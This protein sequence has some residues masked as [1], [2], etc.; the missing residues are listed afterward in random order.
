MRYAVC[1]TTKGN[2]HVLREC[3]QSVRDTMPH[4]ALIHI[5]S[6][7]KPQGEAADILR[8]V[9]KDPGF[10]PPVFV[11]GCSRGEGRRLAFEEAKKRAPDFVVQS[12][13]TD[14]VYF[15][16]TRQLFAYHREM[17]GREDVFLSASGVSICPPALM[18]ALGGWKEGWQVLEDR[19][20]WWRAAQMGKFVYAPSEGIAEHR[21]R[22]GWVGRQVESLH[23]RKHGKEMVDLHG[24]EIAAFDPT[25]PRFHPRDAAWPRYEAAL[26]R[27]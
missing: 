6:A 26:R 8:E 10:A 3:L 11:P 17:P 5:V 19:V 22:R 16:A 21:N 1:I 2:A 23:Y 9:A 25:D 20:V 12:V 7:D 27:R 13:D 15:P 4:E 14:V 24:Q 18:D